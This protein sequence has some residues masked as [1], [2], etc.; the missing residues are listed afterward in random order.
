MRGVACNKLR[1]FSKQVPQ[2][3]RRAPKDGSAVTKP[4]AAPFPRKVPP[5]Q[6][7]NRLWFGRELKSTLVRCPRSDPLRSAQTPCIYTTTAILPVTCCTHGELPPGPEKSASERGWECAPRHRTR[8]FSLGWWNFAW[9]VSFIGLRTHRTRLSDGARGYQPHH[10]LRAHQSVPF[11]S[12]WRSRWLL[13]PKN[14]FHDAAFFFMLLAFSS[15][16]TA[17]AGGGLSPRG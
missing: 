12:L 6:P 8:L 17:L 15:T 14:V 5:S 9:E 4:N 16:S 7:S 1:L 13:E 3:S 2:T 10:P 11:I